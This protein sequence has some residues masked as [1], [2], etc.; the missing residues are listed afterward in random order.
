MRWCTPAHQAAGASDTAPDRAR[1]NQSGP[2][3]RRER[4][5]LGCTLTDHDAA[6]ADPGSPSTPS[7]SVAL[8]VPDRSGLVV[9]L[10]PIAVCIDELWSDA[11]EA[12]DVGLS[13]HLLDAK[14]CLNRALALAQPRA[15]PLV[16]LAVQPVVPA[17]APAPAPAPDADWATRVASMLRH[18]SS[19]GVPSAQPTLRLVRDDRAR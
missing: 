4:P 10:L 14:R 1:R 18:P 9:T 7:E 6:K 15:T 12:G 19:H 2:F 5:I 17:P 13:L 16:S 11:V 3:D 8:G